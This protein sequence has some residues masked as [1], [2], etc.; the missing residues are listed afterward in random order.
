MKFCDVSDTT[1]LEN[2]ELHPLGSGA[3]VL[4]TSIFG[5]YAQDDEYGSRAINP[6]EFLHNQ[7]TRVQ[8]PFSLRMFQRSNGLM[9][10]QANINA[11]CTLLD[12][13]DLDRFIQELREKPY[14]IIGISAIQQNIK[15]VAKMCALIREHQSAVKIVVGGHISNMKDL[16]MRFDADYV[17]RGEGVRW[18]RTFLNEDIARS[19]N[20][21]LIPS[22]INRR[23]LGLNLNT[24]EGEPSATIIP[25]V[26]CPAGCNFCST[27]AMFGGKGKFINFYKT[28]D[29]LFDIMCQLEKEMGVW[30]F[31][32]MD[33]NFLL[34]RKRALR[35]LE[36]MQEHAKSWA[37]YV[38]ASAD[39]LEN[40]TMDQLVGLGISWVW[41]G[42]EG[43]DSR[44]GKLKNIDT[45]SLVR[46]LQSNGIRVSGSTIIGLEEHTPENIDKAI[47]WA[48]SY[49]TEFHQ[50]MLYTAPQ[51]TP[52]HEELE[53][54]GTLL[55]ESE[56][57][58]SDIHGQ[59]RLNFRHPH[60]EE[61]QASEFLLRAFQRDFEVNGPSVMRILPTILKGWIKYKNH[62]DVRI[63]KR[64]AK[65]ME[66][67]PVFYA[68]ALWA[69][70]RWFKG[71]S[72]VTEKMTGVLN[73]IYQEFGIKSRVAAPLVGQIVLYH[74]RKEEKRLAGNYTYEP[75]T[76]Y[77]NSAKAVQPRKKASQLPE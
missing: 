62:P 9:L 20:H 36:L 27:S 42:L 39:A 16:E 11:R 21:P 63:R 34:Y 48:I 29:E 18:F 2:Q 33:E 64:F 59:Y 74:L 14:D 7:V 13:P 54:M 43:K 58:L 1:S 26:G 50:F 38:F 30:S 6:M 22:G 53:K 72:R 71:N 40:Y 46:E 77:E 15:K 70:R 49:E 12:Y 37:L 76:F 61:A 41:I 51:G 10:I 55:D 24:K 73:D 66:K 23:C 32:V 47:E 65:E 28:G 4:L 8:G 56:I 44:Y 5:P 19:I 3:R 52:M 67:I 68:G 25:S 60:I 75:P 31:F 45:K 57:D 17:V 69:A 35:L